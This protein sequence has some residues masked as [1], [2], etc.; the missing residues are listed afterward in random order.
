MPTKEIDFTDYN[1]W[2]SSTFGDDADTFAA[3]MLLRFGL[4]G[5]DAEPD[6]E[7]AG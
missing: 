1:A 3:A 7:T 4:P 2:V 6:A 5:D